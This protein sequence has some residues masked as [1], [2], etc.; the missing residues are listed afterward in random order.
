MLLVPTV[1]YGDIVPDCDREED[2]SS[3]PGST[4]SGDTG[5]TGAY[6]DADGTNNY[7]WAMA[8]AHETFTVT[9]QRTYCD[10]FYYIYT[11]GEADMFLWDGQFG[12]MGAYATASAYCDPTDESD[13]LTLSPGDPV[14]EGW[15]YLEGAGYNGRHIS[16]SDNGGA[17]DGIYR[18]GSWHF[19][20]GQSVHA[21]LVERLPMVCASA[22]GKAF[23]LAPAARF[24]RHF[25]VGTP[26]G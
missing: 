13:S 2:F 19:D 8:Q 17:P 7:S 14:H 24:N 20:P 12:Y 16:D 4:L 11:Y 10:Y 1:A 9:G 5:Y 22:V 3:S 18:F 21:E 26:A 23:G 6:T 25:F 15:V